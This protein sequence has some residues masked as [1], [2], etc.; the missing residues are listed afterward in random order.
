MFGSYLKVDQVVLKIDE[1]VYVLSL[2]T[3]LPAST[4]P[5]ADEQL[6]DSFQPIQS[7]LWSHTH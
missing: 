3:R 2:V 4:L 6:C 5:S 7:L 1:A